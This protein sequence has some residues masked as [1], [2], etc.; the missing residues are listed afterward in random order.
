MT[1]VGLYLAGDSVVHRLAPGVKLLALTGF[2]VVLVGFRSL[3]VVL[4]GAVL[5][6]VGYLAA[7]FGLRVLG[8]QLWPLRWILL[9]LIPFQIW[10][11]GWESAAVLVGTLVV[12]VAAAAL[13][14]LT[15][16]V[17]A[18]LDT[19]IRL[20]TPLRR[21]G[22]DPQRLGLAFALV[23]R[24][25][26]ALLEIAALSR[27]ARRARGLE[28]SPRAVLVPFVVRSVRYAQATGDALAARGLDD[29]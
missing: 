8:R 21:L 22:V 29:P 9:L 23:I 20:A 2:A 15:T 19:V 28:R 3:P 12:G 26:P 5:V 1:T 16:T 10:S 11:V 6:S 27:D 4:G 7:G 14:S 24:S 18:L 25:V 17:T 13:V